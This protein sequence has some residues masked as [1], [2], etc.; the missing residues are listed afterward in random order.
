MKFCHCL[1]LA[2]ALLATPGLYGQYYRGKVNRNNPNAQREPQP[3][4]PSRS[5]FIKEEPRPLTPS[6]KVRMD[7]CRRS[8][9]QDDPE[10]LKRAMGD[11]FDV[12]LR[13]PD[14]ETLL[15][16]AV[17]ERKKKCFLFLLN[18]KADVNC[19]DKFG[20]SP[21][22]LCSRDKD[23]DFAAIL[24]NAGAVTSHQDKVSLWNVFHKAAAENMGTATLSVLVREKSGLN[25]HDREGRTPLHL[26]VSRSPKADYQV[27][28]ILLKNGADVNAL[29]NQGRTPLDLTRQRDIVD[30]LHKYHDRHNKRSGGRGRPHRK[31]KI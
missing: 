5:S 21:L 2:G 18:L 3:Q 20:L 9:L 17:K 31:R 15:Q 7:N 24:I 11:N 28:E 25:A 6:E 14:R 4:P 16:F 26:A 27:V 22:F 30:L 13:E 8:I 1:L 10:L 12:N 23:A 19:T 29:D